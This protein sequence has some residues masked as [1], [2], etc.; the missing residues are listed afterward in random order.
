MSEEQKRTAERIG[1]RYWPDDSPEGH[2]WTH[3]DDNGKG[4]GK[5]YRDEEVIELL[6]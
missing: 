4:P 6:P 1:W 3:P 5:A 2:H